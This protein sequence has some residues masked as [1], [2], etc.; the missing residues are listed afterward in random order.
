MLQMTLP[1]AW[2]RDK[3]LKKNVKK[4]NMS[5]TYIPL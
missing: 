4:K 5:Y 2:D 3:Q 1:W